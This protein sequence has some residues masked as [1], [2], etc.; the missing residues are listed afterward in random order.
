M[1]LVHATVAELDGY[2]VVIRGP[3]GSGK[4]DL[5]LRLI[6][7]GGRLVSDDYVSLSARDGTLFA[8]PPETIAG[9]LEVRGLGLVQVPWLSVCEVALVVDLVASEDVPRLPAMSWALLCGARVRRVALDPFEVSAV[10]KVRLA[11]QS[12]HS[13]II[14]NK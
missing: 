6:E 14:Q 4:S 12:V 13:N 10:A 3:S 2:G 9:L 1:S 5:A 7:A 8:T 11:V